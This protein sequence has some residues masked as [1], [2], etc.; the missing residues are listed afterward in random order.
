MNSRHPTLSLYS[1]EY[2]YGSKRVVELSDPYKSTSEPR[3]AVTGN[4]K[5]LLISINQMRPLGDTALP[6]GYRATNATYNILCLTCVVNTAEYTA[7]IYETGMVTTRTGIQLPR[8]LWFLDFRESYNGFSRT[9]FI[10]CHM[11]EW[12]S[13]KLGVRSRYYCL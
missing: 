9:L 10:K 4:G 5:N 1:E 7:G 12:D 11:W 3:R 13:H 8:A 6:L 2:R